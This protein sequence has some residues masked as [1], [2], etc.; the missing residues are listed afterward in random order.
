[1]TNSQMPRKPPPGTPEH[2]GQRYAEWRVA[3]EDWEN[4]SSDP[5]G[6][7]PRVISLITDYLT[8]QM[9]ADL[10]KLSSARYGPGLPLNR[11][12]FLL[13]RMGH[14][15][16]FATGLRSLVAGDKLFGRWG[17]YSFP[18]LFKEVETD[19]ECFTQEFSRRDEGAF[20]I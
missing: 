1:M 17:E 12:I 6:L 20:P 13:I 5:S 16:L 18:A 2:F 14:Y 4:D 7:R 19:R 8:L 11:D 3:F 9:A 10:V 15:A